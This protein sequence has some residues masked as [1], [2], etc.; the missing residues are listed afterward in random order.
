MAE[1]ERFS[2]LYG[3]GIF[4]LDALSKRLLRPAPQPLFQ[5]NGLLLSNPQPQEFGVNFITVSMRSGANL[6]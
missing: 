5:P 1:R 6:I 3:F 4:S 2:I